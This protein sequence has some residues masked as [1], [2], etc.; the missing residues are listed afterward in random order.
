MS[1]LKA[2]EH[3]T[4]VVY[5]TS[6]TAGGGW[7]LASKHWF[8]KEYPS[9]VTFVNSGMPG[10]N[11]DVGVAHVQ[12]KVLDFKPSL[13]LIEF[14]INDA[15]IKFN[16]PVEKGA[17]N[18]DK[19]VQAIHAQNAKTAIVLQIMNPVWDATDKKSFSNRPNYDAYNDN[20]RNYARDHQLPLL[21]HWSN[22]RKI[23]DAEPEKFKTMIPDGTHPSNTASV[24]VTWPLIQSVLVASAA[25]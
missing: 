2:G 20:Y 6:L 4:V 10:Q 22:W 19:I 21:D 17:A 23:Q 13:V 5:G 1:R 11:S 25:P 7:T 18:L 12:D 15:H 24:A 16:M 14:A 3:E 8:E 9:Q